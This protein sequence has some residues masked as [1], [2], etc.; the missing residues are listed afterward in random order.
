MMQVRLT[1][2]SEQ[3]AA[4]RNRS[5]SRNAILPSDLATPIGAVSG[6]T[7]GAK[8]GRRPRTTQ[9]FSPVKITR[10]DGSV[11]VIT[12]A[13]RKYNGRTVPAKVIDLPHRIKASDLPAVFAD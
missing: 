13:A 1:M 11:S 7:V 9:R 4:E 5:E 6:L 2:T 10:P 8:Y 3:L 12:K